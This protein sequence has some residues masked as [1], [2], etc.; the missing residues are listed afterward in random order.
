MAIVFNGVTVDKVIFNGTEAETVKFNGVTVFE[1]KPQLDTPQNVTADG[2]VVSWDEVENATS[3]EVYADGASIGT[4]PPTYNN[5]HLA[6][7][8]DS[9]EWVHGYYS[10]NGSQYI[11]FTQTEVTL[12][13][14]RTLVLKQTGAADYACLHIDTSKFIKLKQDNAGDLP[15]PSNVYGSE[16][17]DLTNY[18][19]DGCYISYGLYD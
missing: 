16:T 7:F 15:A 13:N 18:L 14:V 19:K 17:V 4:Y 5:I 9:A 12:N 8:G 3:Y 1:S 10:L 6:T 11:E 2:T